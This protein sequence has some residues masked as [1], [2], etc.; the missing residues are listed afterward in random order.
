MRRISRG[1][2]DPAAG[3]PQS[4]DPMVGGKSSL[5]VFLDACC[6]ARGGGLSAAIGILE[7]RR[8]GRRQVSSEAGVSSPLAPSGQA[9]SRAFAACAAA[10]DPWPGT[11][12][13]HWHGSREAVKALGAA[14]RVVPA[15]FCQPRA[16][17][18]R[19]AAMIMTAGHDLCTQTPWR[20]VDRVGCGKNPESYAGSLVA[21][22][23]PYLLQELA[24]A[25]RGESAFAAG[26]RRDA[27]SVSLTSMQGSLDRAAASG[28]RFRSIPR[29]PVHRNHRAGGG[30]SSLPRFIGSQ[31][32]STRQ[33]LNGF[34]RT[35][36]TVHCLRFA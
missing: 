3:R 19:A 22:E 27:A 9:R 24:E 13:R 34:R 16:N 18:F 23:D 17:T 15:S 33:S 4:P 31:G 25:A 6:S 5:A 14:Q 26:T 7:V 30:A 11:V 2:T 10:R 20:P 28:Q 36:R 35:W 21:T 29:H 32:R 12:A 1:L 8:S